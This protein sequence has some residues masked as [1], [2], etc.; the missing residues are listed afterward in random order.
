L[1]YV[2]GTDGEQRAAI[3]ARQDRIV[4]VLRPTRLEQIAR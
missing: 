2:T 3:R 4:V 1:K